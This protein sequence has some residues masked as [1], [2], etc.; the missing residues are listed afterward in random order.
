MANR[1]MDPI[2]RLMGLRYK[3]HPWHGVDVGPEVP[4]VVTAFIEMVTTDTVKYEVDKMSGYLRI[5]RPQK[6]SSVLPALYGFI[7][8]TLS[9][10]SVAQ[11]ARG[12]TD[13]KDLSGDGDPLDICVLT[14][15]NIVH[16]NLLVHA[17]PIGGFRMIDGNQADDKIIAVLKDDAVYG[18]IQSI[19]QCPEA[20]ITRLRHYF[21]TYKDL[22]GT[23][24]D[25][26]ITHV[27]GV[28]ECH[29][30]INASLDDYRKKFENLD[31]VLSQY[32]ITKK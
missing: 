30:V 16:G 17:I 15:K 13:R 3:S 29:Q 8:Q 32:G 14:E 26:E 27:Y 10:E 31:I 1:I 9:D 28:E 20:V 21:L 4:D 6:Y 24:R 22:P 2:E 19:D 11:I 7:P 18:H 25:C 23:V 5:D 12:K